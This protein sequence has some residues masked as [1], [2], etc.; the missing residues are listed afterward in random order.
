MCTPAICPIPNSSVSEVDLDLSDRLRQTVREAYEARTPLCIQG[1]GS[2]T[3]YGRD[4][5]GE[6]LQVGGH[7]GIVAYEPAELT[8]TVRCGTPIAEVEAVLAEKNQMLA[9][10]PPRHAGTATIGG[11]IACG[12]SGPR[13]MSAGSVRDFLLGLRCINGEGEILHFGGAVMKNVAGFDAFRLMV[14]AMGTLGVLLEATFKVLPR[15]ERQETL[16][17]EYE[18]ARAIATMNEWASRPLPV[19]ATAWHD[20]RLYVRLEG[21]TEA[22]GSARR[23]LGGDTPENPDE[24]WRDIRDHR[25][26]WLSRPDML[27]RIALPPATP[28]LPI[29]GEWM[30]EWGGAQ[31]WLRSAMA[32]KFVREMC[33]RHRG[34]ATIYRG[35]E[36]DGSIFHPLSAPV[37]QLHRRLKEA[38][39]PRGILNPQRLYREL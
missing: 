19:G 23:Q 24:Y 17:F 32:S 8:I 38:F 27:W 29:V 28:M 6:P 5:L 7:R 20:G 9:F 4:A 10:E 25:H 36:R 30:I 18:A 39:D 22:V 2:K 33:A 16:V 11:I 26:P 15:P 3:F 31:R 37:M 1:G 35:G 13:R 14:G 21:S 34:H 12:F